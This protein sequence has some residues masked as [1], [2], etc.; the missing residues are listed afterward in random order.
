VRT[1]EP[2]LITR[3]ALGF[4][5]NSGLLRPKVTY[6]GVDVAGQ[7]EA[8]GVSVIHFER[9]DEVFGLCLRYPQVP[10]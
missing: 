5:V 10:A 8:V 3:C 9:G 4:R 1:A 6:V 7:V 2:D